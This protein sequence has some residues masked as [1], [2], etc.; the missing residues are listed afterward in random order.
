MLRNF[1][2]QPFDIQ[3]IFSMRDHNLNETKQWLRPPHINRVIL[4]NCPQ[5][6]TNPDNIF[7]NIPL[8]FGR[9]L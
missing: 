1:L 3:A 6:R 9:W 4:I 2:P 8:S 5:I 7:I